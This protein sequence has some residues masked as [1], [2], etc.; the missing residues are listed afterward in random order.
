MRRAG[1]KFINFITI[2]IIIFGAI[3]MNA[4]AK[5][6]TWM[7]AS[8][9]VL[10][11]QLEK[12]LGPDA[13]ERL[14]RGMKQVG[15]FWREEDGGPRQFEDFVRTHFAKD[16]RALNE[17]FL[18]FETLLEQLD[19]NMN[20][21]I[22]AFRAQADLD[23]GPMVPLD[24]VFAGYDPSAH[25]MDDFFANKAAFAAL[26]N[27]PLTTLEQRLEEGPH[28]S[29]RQWAETRLAQRFSK[30]IPADVS[31][32][33]A[34]AAA[35]ADRY[36]AGYN[37][38]MHHLLDN[39]GRRLFPPKMR[40]LSHWNLRDEI[41]AAY[42]DLA[43]GLARQRMIMK[44][45]K[46]IVNQ[47]IPEVVIDNPR[48]DWNPFTNE[49]F[50][51][52]AK[53]YEGIDAKDLDINDSPE[54]NRRYTIILE[55]FHASQKVDAFSPTAPTLIDRRFNES[56]EIPEER[57]RSMFEQVLSSS[58]AGKVAEL[59][60]TRLGR[61]LEPFDIWYNGFRSSGAYKQDE[62][63]SIVRKRYPDASAYKKDIPYLLTKLGFTAEKA[64]F[65]AD[66]IAVDP[67]RGSGHAWG[68]EMRGQIAHLRTRV[69]VE[70]MDYKGFNI[71]VH[72]MG[73][74][75]EQVLS[76]NAIDHSLLRGVPN[77][78]FTEAMAFVFQSRDLE[79]LGIAESR[80]EE[81]EAMKTLNDF[82]GA[83]EIAGVAL[84]DM[85]IWHW[86]YD[87]P[88]ADPAELKE[89][90]IQIAKDVWNKYYAEHF[91]IRDVYLLA[92]YSHILHS[93]LYIPDYPL[94]HFI[95]F[96]VG[97][98]MKQSGNIGYEFE[99]MVTAGNI[100]PDLWMER[101][102]GAPVGP[103]ALLKAAEDALEILSK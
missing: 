26:L 84:V 103:E 37:I 85:G 100:A 49:V 94:G 69:G 79:L 28:W 33:L 38:W 47:T 76:V 97:E 6:P 23:I 52:G 80:N 73:H 46:R 74:N 72:E 36:V 27:F 31:M 9:S 19:G 4:H 11:Q 12:E 54:P 99:R 8:M 43:N 63:D 95:A 92:V 87:H 81:S 34:E 71:A 70:G 60:K 3:S 88:Q 55:T 68:G 90:T 67:A 59:I 96:Q 29:R 91:G 89:A 102:T 35:H 40:L 22:L 21:I 78:A 45:M 65:I 20:E 42:T 86:M 32:S 30:R 18:R 62:L 39:E 1:N 75:V 7:D 98:K 17:L 66:H 57:V 50:R 2:V 58:V 41:K 82:W 10:E 14:M 101:A 61:S 24:H 51:A 15:R 13:V 48:V 56:R 53:D 44:V 77:T 64:E 25:V 93:F 83:Y 5:K 16:E